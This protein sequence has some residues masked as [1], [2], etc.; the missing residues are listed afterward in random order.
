M[1][2]VGYYVRNTSEALSFPLP[3][4][5]A[6]REENMKSDCDQG[7]PASV[8]AGLDDDEEGDRCSICLNDFRDRAVLPTCAHEFCFECITIWTGSSWPSAYS[9]YP[10][11]YPPTRLRRAEPSLSAL[12]SSRRRA[13]HPP[14]PRSA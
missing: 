4:T 13:H 6:T 3:L 1:R 9:L 10:H 8:S 5:D 12:H 2:Y 11:T 14:H 7:A